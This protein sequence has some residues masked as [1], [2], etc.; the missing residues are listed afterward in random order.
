MPY[1]RRV[2]E[3]PRKRHIRFERPDGGLH[4][5]EL[6][7]VDGFSADSALLYHRRPPT[8]IVKAEAVD[9]STAAVEVAANRPLLPRHLRTHALPAGGD[10][11]AGRRLLLANDDVRLLIAAPAAGPGGVS[12]LY[13]NATGDELVY[14][15]SGSATLE[16]VYGAL[17]VRA[18]DYVVIP[19][20]TTHR[21]VPNGPGAPGGPGVSPGES[22]LRL[23][24][25]EAR[26]HV[27]P[28]RR[29]LSPAGQFLEHSPYC[30]RDLRAP[31]EPLLVD[32]GETPVLVRTR[33]GLT[34][35]TYLH[36]PFD[37][38]GWDGCLYP[39]AFNIGDFEPIVGRLHQPPP[40]HQTFEGPNFVVCS[41]VPRLFDFHPEAVPVPY[42]HANVDSDEVLFYVGGDFMSRKGSGIGLGS[43]SLHPAGFIHGPQPG[44]VEAATGKPGTDEVA[45]MVDTFRPLGLGPAAR[46]TQDPEYAW[47]WAR[48]LDR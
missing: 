24:V 39:W 9:E 10:A 4:S 43:I 33:D 21:W 28:P 12:E 32:D 3:V 26:G 1:Y 5:E 42:N 38:V 44:S 13:R 47:T 40:V 22:G 15:E 14:V 31:A 2:G 34:R 46:E 48:G 23:L 30:E 19:T 27:R 18:G 17:E 29:Y 6:M 37:V 45:V 8:A 25:L 20:S 11:V 7:G 16:S 41:F 36:H 35:Y